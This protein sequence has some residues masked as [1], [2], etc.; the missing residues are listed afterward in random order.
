MM[1]SHM[2]R[3][4]PYL[5]LSAFEVPSISLLLVKPYVNTMLIILHKILIIGLL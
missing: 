5:N 3:S 2:L 1:L 4:L